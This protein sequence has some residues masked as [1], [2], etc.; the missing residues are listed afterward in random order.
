MSSVCLSQASDF[1]SSVSCCVSTRQPT[2][3]VKTIAHNQG[4]SFLTC[5]SSVSHLVFASLFGYLTKLRSKFKWPMA[6]PLLCLKDIGWHSVLSFH[7][8]LRKFSCQIQTSTGLAVAGHSTPAT[9]SSQDWLFSASMQSHGNQHVNKMTHQNKLSAEKREEQ[10]DGTCK[11]FH[12]LLK[13]QQFQ[14]QASCHFPKHVCAWH[15]A[16]WF[17]S[18]LFQPCDVKRNVREKFCNEIHGGSF[19]TRTET[20]QNPGDD[21]ARRNRWPGSHFKF[22]LKVM[23]KWTYELQL[24]RPRLP[25]SSQWPDGSIFASQPRG[26]EFDP[27][28]CSMKMFGNFWCKRTFFWQWA[29]FAK[30]YLTCKAAFKCGGLLFEISD[31]LPGWGSPHDHTA[32]VDPFSQRGI[33]RQFCHASFERWVCWCVVQK[34][35]L[36]RSF[37][38]RTLFYFDILVHILWSPLHPKHIWMKCSSKTHH[39]AEFENPWSSCWVIM[40]RESRR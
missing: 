19:W 7:S 14:L 2:T 34:K 4:L 32:V 3:H 36:M 30:F 40:G 17:L 29:T 27:H 37:G 33:S 10:I 31:D 26:C 13:V 28:S 35:K 11:L 12:T 6:S 21:L 5:F 23:R 24:A 38:P 8:D 16:L 22:L 39:H 15:V 25:G 1:P 9:K 20:V 18:L